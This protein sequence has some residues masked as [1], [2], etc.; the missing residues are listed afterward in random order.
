M[1]PCYCVR[2]QQSPGWSVLRPIST[3]GNL[4]HVSGPSTTDVSPDRVRGDETDLASVLQPHAGPRSYPPVCPCAWP[5]GYPPVSFAKQK[6]LLGRARAW[7]GA[8][9]MCVEG[10]H[11]TCNLTLLLVMWQSDRVLL[12][13]MNSGRAELMRNGG[14]LKE[15]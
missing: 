10:K 3:S 8:Q 6:F 7:V 15:Q 2:L 13:H 11:A 14:N 5:A 1:P 9:E 12:I 4:F